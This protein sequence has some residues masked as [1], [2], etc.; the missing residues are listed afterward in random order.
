[1]SYRDRYKTIHVKAF[2]NT[3][4]GEY[5]TESHYIEVLDDIESKVSD[6]YYE[7]DKIKGLS[8]IDDIKAL[9]EELKNKLY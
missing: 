8:E 3:V 7:L 5:I 4:S 1:M 9:C 6:I 2:D